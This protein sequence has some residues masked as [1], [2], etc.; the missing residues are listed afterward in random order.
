[1]PN[2]IS[3]DGIESS[4]PDFPTA[5]HFLKSEDTP[6]IQVGTLTVFLLTKAAGSG[7]ELHELVKINVAAKNS[8]KINWYVLG[9]NINCKFSMLPL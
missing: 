6:W 9:R 3:S 2:A 8:P 4:I 5:Y 7:T 1:M